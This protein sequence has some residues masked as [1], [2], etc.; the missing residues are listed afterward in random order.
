[1]KGNTMIYYVKNR[2]KF[3]EFLEMLSKEENL[4]FKEL[5]SLLGLVEEN[6]DIPVT[7]EEL[8]SQFNDFP[9]VVQFEREAIIIYPERK[10]SD[11]SI[12]PK[13][14][15]EI[16][17]DDLSVETVKVFLEKE[18]EF[19]VPTSI[20]NLETKQNEGWCVINSKWFLDKLEKG[21]FYYCKWNGIAGSW[22]IALTYEGRF[23]F[24]NLSNR[25]MLF[26]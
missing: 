26:I 2:E 11:F 20:L 10:I 22:G 14:W 17:D 16:L 12:T 5:E 3:Q 1:M 8:A 6:P 13:M 23:Y 25:P 15:N 7:A 4:S 18:D 19:S 24:G 9:M 21:I